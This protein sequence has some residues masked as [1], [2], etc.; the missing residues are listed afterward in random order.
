MR[1]KG[2]GEEEEEEEEP[3]QNSVHLEIQASVAPWSPV[4]Q[5]VRHGITDASPHW[6]HSVLR[7]PLFAQP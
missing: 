3:K 2:G 7:S 4:S 1:R 6:E 5:G